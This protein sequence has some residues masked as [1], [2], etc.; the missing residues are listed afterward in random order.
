MRPKGCSCFISSTRILEPEILVAPG[1]EAFHQDCRAGNL[2]GAGR[3]DH[4]PGFRVKDS[5]WNPGREFLHHLQGPYYYYYVIQCARLFDRRLFTRIRYPH[6][7][8][9][10]DE[11]TAH[12]LFFLAS[13]VVSSSQ[14]L[15]HYVQHP[16]SIMTGASVRTLDGIEAACRR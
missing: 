3:K 1:R 12:R 13:R 8:L 14:V 5:W 4:P 11:F 7:R 2:G 6:G 16:G 9:R 15:Y 10:E